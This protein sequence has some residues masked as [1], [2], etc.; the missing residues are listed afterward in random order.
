MLLRLHSRFA[1]ESSRRQCSWSEDGREQLARLTVRNV[2]CRESSKATDPEETSGLWLCLA[3]SCSCVSKCMC[4]QPCLTLCDA[5]DCSPPGS[6]VHE[7]FQARIQEWV[8]IPSSRG[9]S[10]PR[11]ERVFPVSPALCCGM[12]APSSSLTPNDQT[13][14]NND[15]R[16]VSNQG[17]EARSRITD[18]SGHLVKPKTKKV[19]EMENA[20]ITPQEP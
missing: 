6:S 8:A 20:D 18:L 19:K 12:Q 4:A 13:L 1:G 11:T 2:D 15:L 10:W 7:I 17:Q 16:G 9:S 5:M 14:G 3:Y